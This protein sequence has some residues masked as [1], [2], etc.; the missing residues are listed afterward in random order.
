MSSLTATDRPVRARCAVAALFFTNGFLFA[1]VVPRYPEIKSGLDLSNAALGTAIAAMPLGALM[2]GLAASPLI[3]RYGSARTAVVSQLLM[4]FNILLVGTAPNFAVL[5]LGLFLAGSLDAITDVA[6]NAHGLRVQRRYGRSILNSFHGLWSVGAVVGGIAGAGAA[7]LGLSLAVHLAIVGAL[8]VGSALT[9]SRF[10][11][12]GPEDA[13][14]APAAETNGANGADGANG[15]DGSRA[16]A[17]RRSWLRRPVLMAFALLG[18]MTAA[19][20]VIEDAPASWGSNYLQNELGSSPFIGGMAFMA[21]QGTQT[22]ARLLGDR[23]V[24]RLGDRTTA[25]IGGLLVLVGMG[26]ALLWPSVPT[27]VLGFGLCGIGIAT[28]I[29]AAFHAADEIPGLWPGAGI[30]V[31]AFLLRVGFLVS[32]P[33]IG[34]IADAESIRLG[35]VLVPVAG[36]ALLATSGILDTRH[37]DADTRSTDADTP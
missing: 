34:L 14:R 31:A 11:L 2:L 17:G 15:S 36:L 5:C 26:V 6:M 32:P 7:Q 37:V 20:A 8:A 29:P 35:L 19:T 21:L 1:N 33:V 4:G 12:P 18:L 9:S 27:T 25:R 22:V 13:E 30:T 3:K 16:A 23:V 24:H 10:L 28:I